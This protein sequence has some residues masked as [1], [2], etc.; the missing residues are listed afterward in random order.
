MMQIHD[1]LWPAWDP[2]RGPPP[3]TGRVQCY[4]VPP[5]RDP[6]QP[7]ESDLV[8][9]KPNLFVRIGYQRITAWLA[10][11]AITT[12]PPRSMSVGTSATAPAVTDTVMGF[13]ICRVLLSS[14]SVLSLYTARLVSVFSPAQGNGDL[15]EIG[16]HDTVASG[17]WSDGTAT[18]GG[19]TTLTDSGK[20]WTTN[21]WAAGEVMIVSGTGLGQK[22]TISSNTATVLTVSSSWTTNP[23]A[24]SVYH[25]A[26]QRLFAHTDIAITKSGQALN[27][28]WSLT[29]NYV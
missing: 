25:V 12:A 19:A 6:W 23:D 21:E 9:D 27:V 20:A 11:N 13:E 28:V 15:R 14:A 10:S 2:S 17:G 5:D 3:I 7:R 16:L 24:T 22:R 18:A 8:L 4:L 26:M 1:T 29:Q